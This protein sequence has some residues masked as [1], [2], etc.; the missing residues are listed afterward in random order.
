MG[1]GSLLI[2]KLLYIADKVSGVLFKY[3]SSAQTPNQLG[4]VSF[5]FYFPHPPTVGHQAR[6]VKNEKH[7]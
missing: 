3:L 4:W 7:G 5:Y 1:S 2:W 6:Q